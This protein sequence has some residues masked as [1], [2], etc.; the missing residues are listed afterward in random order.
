[1]HIVTEKELGAF[2]RKKKNVILLFYASWCP[3]CRGFLKILE[4]NTDR[5]RNDVV[6]IN[7]DDDKSPIWDDYKIDIVPTLIAFHNGKEFARRDGVPQVGL[8]L[9]ELL[10]LD[11]ML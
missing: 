6:G 9:D 4:K 7:I 11:G 3:Y 1:M 5:L 8:G 2:I 10:Q